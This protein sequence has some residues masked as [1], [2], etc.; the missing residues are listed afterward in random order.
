MNIPIEEVLNESG[1]KEIGPQLLTNIHDRMSQ[2]HNYN[3][4]NIF[5]C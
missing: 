4:K 5:Y 3:I 2:L 1:Q